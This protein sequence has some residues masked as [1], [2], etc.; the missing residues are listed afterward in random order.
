MAS[1]T[2][3]IGRQIAAEMHKQV[4]MVRNVLTST[5]P[6]GALTQKDLFVSHNYLCRVCSMTINYVT[7]CELKLFQW[8]PLSVREALNC[9][10]FRVENF[11]VLGDWLS[12]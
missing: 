2:L 6:S 9:A 7:M 5:L 3:I 11:Q 12:N 1:L 4:E 8:R 10:I